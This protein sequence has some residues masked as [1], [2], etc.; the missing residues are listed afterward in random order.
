MCA[1]SGLSPQY[2]A[3]RATRGI[4]M[5]SKLRRIL[6]KKNVDLDALL[7]RVRAANTRAFAD[8]CA[9]ERMP[10]EERRLRKRDQDRRLKIAAEMRRFRKSNGEAVHP[11]VNNHQVLPSNVTVCLRET[12]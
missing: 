10:D 6:K 5:G 12:I 7:K 11:D 9:L 8:L 2:L 3:K 4:M 1:V